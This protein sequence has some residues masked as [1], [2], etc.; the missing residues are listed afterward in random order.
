[1]LWPCAGVF[2]F[3]E[4]IMLLPVFL[5]QKYSYSYEPETGH[6]FL[7]DNEY[8]SHAYL[9]GDDAR[10]FREEIEQIDNLPEGEYKTGLLTENAVKFYL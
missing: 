3:K 5:G 9:Q 8:K 6:Y 4:L 2:L 7:H 1:M 10:I